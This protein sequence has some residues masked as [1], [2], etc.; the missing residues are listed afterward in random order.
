M[1]KSRTLGTTAREVRKPVK[2]QQFTVILTGPQARGLHLLAERNGIKAAGLF[3]AWLLRE[4]RAVFGK[5][6]E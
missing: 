6:L 3:R 5:E 2:T 1:P 4:F